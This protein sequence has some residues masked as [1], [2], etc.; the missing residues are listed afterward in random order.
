MEYN[1][2]KY[3]QKYFKFFTSLLTKSFNIKNADKEGLIKWKFFDSIHEGKTITYIA[4]DGKNN[5]VGQYTN[6][7][8]KIARKNRIYKTMDCV[9]MTTDINHR[10]MGIIS[11]LSKLVYK[12]INEKK[13]DFSIGF[14]N[15]EGVKVDKNSSNYGYKIVGRFARYYK[16][17]VYRKKTPI[18][19]ELATAFD[20]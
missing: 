13:Y 16:F 19:L 6:L 3:S 12:E 4:L 7:P 14:S 20:Y 9:D 2:E 8:F 18:K 11:K 15:D 5:V 1:F 10:G 17:I